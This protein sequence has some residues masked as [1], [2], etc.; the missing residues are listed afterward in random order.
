MLFRSFGIDAESRALAGEIHTLAPLYACKRLFVQRRAVKKYADVS[1]LNGEALTR[2]LESRMG[3]RIAGADDELAFARVVAG[4]EKDE[5][6]NAESLDLAAQYAA[7]ATLSDDGRHKH[8]GGVLFRVPN[9]VEPENLL[10]LETHGVGQSGVQAWTLGEHHLRRR[11]GFAL[12]DAGHDLT[13]ALDQ[14]HYCIFCH[15]Q[16]KDSC[17]RGMRDKPAAGQTV[18]ALKKSHFG[19][20]LNGCPLEEKISEMHTAKTE[21][22][23]LTALAIVTVDNPMAAGTGHRICN[24]CMKEIGR[25]HV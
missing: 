22:F 11:E 13:R 7:W 17:S 4:W 25:A 12:T 8:A 24:D 3:V 2:A 9:K 20:T 16:G 23:S 15:N 18:G 14:A 19:V 1:P 5:A 6:A 10:P 21:G